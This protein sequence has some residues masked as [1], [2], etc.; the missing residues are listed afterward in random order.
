[1]Y[2]FTYLFLHRLSKIKQQ[3]EKRAYLKYHDQILV[4]ATGIQLK[5]SDTNISDIHSTII[6]FNRRLLQDP[7]CIQRL[8][9]AIP[10]PTESLTD[11]DTIPSLKK[12]ESLI[13][14]YEI[15]DKDL[16]LFDMLD[17]IL[18]ESTFLILFT[19]NNNIFLIGLCTSF[20][21]Q[22]FNH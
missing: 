18:Q 3:V 7:A 13:N 16:E 20:K 19:I 5:E 9:S 2:S 12:L 14:L 22:T 15:Q 8:A 21:S 11:S 10:Q 6:I 1:M 17:H 4:S